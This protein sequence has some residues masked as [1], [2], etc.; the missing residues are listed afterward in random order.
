MPMTKYILFFF[1]L[2]AFTGCK[3]SPE[4]FPA[5]N[6]LRRE[7]ANSITIP[8]NRGDTVIYES[9]IGIC[10]NSDEDAL[11]RFYV[12]HLNEQPYLGLLNVRTNK[13]IL[14]TGDSLYALMNRLCKN[15]NDSLTEWNCFLKNKIFLEMVGE[16]ITNNSVKIYENYELNKEHKYIEKLFT[17]TGNKWTFKTIKNISIN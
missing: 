13:T 5:P 10:G 7:I 2:S 15:N 16:A 3:V 17:Y 9:F 8:F 14:Y 4:N 6:D 1:I 12:P 11:D